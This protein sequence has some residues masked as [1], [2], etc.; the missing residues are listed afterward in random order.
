MSSALHDMCDKKYMNENEGIN[1]IKQYFE[2]DLSK[3]ELFAIEKI[4][5]TM[6]YSKVKKNGFPNLGE[7]TLPYHIVREADLLAAYDFDR[8]LTYKI[9]N[10]SYDILDSY[11]DSLNLFNNRVFKHNEDNLFLTEYGKNKSKEL[12]ETS[13]IRIKNWDRIIKSF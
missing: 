10:S 12:H 5:S 6:S 3:K 7:Y 1:N 13:L 8:T 4:V 2:E 11:T 9:F